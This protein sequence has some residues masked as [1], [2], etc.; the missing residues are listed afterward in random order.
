MTN[1]RDAIR[2]LSSVSR[3]N[4][5]NLPPMP[6]IFPE[7]PAPIDATRRRT[8]TDDGPLGHAASPKALMDAPKK[9]AEKLQAKG[10]FKELLRMEPDSGT[11]NILNIPSKHWKRP[12]AVESHCVVPM[13]S[14][15]E[16]NRDAGRDI[17]FALDNNRP[18]GGFAGLWT[19]WTSVRKVHDSETTNDIY[20]FLTTEPNAE[21]GAIHPKPMP[22]ILTTSEVVDVWMRA[23]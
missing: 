16:F 20:A 10:N 7:Y 17:R 4:A 13:S 12:L 23:P 5:G 8:P 22:V 19:N 11:T 1:S 18:L 9:R 21:V 15:N 2:K 3:D 6:G 14:F